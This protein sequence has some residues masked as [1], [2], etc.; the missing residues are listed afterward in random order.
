MAVRLCYYFEF[1]I[2]FSCNDVSECCTTSAFGVNSVT[3]QFVLDVILK[4]RIFSMV[5]AEF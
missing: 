4:N 1:Q 2:L 5:Q 3:F